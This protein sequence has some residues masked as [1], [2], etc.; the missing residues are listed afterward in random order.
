M[1]ELTEVP[2]ISTDRADFLRKKA[3]VVEGKSGPSFMSGLELVQT[4][5][6]NVKISTG[7]ASFDALIGAECAR[8]FIMDAQAV[9][10]KRRLSPKYS[11]IAGL[12]RRSCAIRSASELSS[13]ET[14]AALKAVHF[15]STQTGLFAPTAYNK[16]L[17]QLVSVS[18]DKL[19]A[20]IT[21]TRT[22]Q[23]PPR[24]SKT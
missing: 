24:S 16:S 2:G 8:V 18:Q 10:L 13:P 20:D 12:A 14:K 9:A 6:S 17:M 1:R 22:A 3:K 19:C 11:G 4:H 7:C 15:S 5:S 23:I 21:N